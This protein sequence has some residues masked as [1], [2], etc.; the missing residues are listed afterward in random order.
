MK[1]AS[2]VLELVLLTPGVTLAHAAPA[3][4]PTVPRNAINPQPLPPRHINSGARIA[5]NP[6]PLP[7]RS[8][9]PALRKA[10]SKPYIGET[11][12]N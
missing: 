12:K 2:K 7:P 1:A 8:A 4:A 9:D 6:Q 10:P 3:P 5:I 11:E